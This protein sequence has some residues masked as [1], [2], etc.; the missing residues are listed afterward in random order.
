M[1]N[2]RWVLIAA[3]SC[4]FTYVNGNWNYRGTI[5]VGLITSPRGGSDPNR[6]R[7]VVIDNGTVQANTNN[8]NTAW[9]AAKGEIFFKQYWYLGNKI[10]IDVYTR[11]HLVL[12]G[13]VT[14]WELWEW[15]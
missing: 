15:K 11:S 5:D 2:K 14:N 7:V 10:Y 3:G 1:E 9:W 13:A 4:D 12:S 8:V 6:F